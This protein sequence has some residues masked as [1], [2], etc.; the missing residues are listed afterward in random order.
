M[1]LALV[2]DA[3]HQN[4]PHEAISA[5]CFG[6]FLFGLIAAIYKWREIAAGVRTFVLTLYGRVG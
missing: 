6:L 5:I 1:S 4:L 2:H 3:A